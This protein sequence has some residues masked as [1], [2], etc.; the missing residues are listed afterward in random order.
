MSVYVSDLPKDGKQDG[1]P[2]FLYCPRCGARNSA[3]PSDYFM[4]DPNTKFRCGE[5]RP[6]VDMVLAR[7]DNRVIEL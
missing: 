1:R 6:L 7:A 3:N 2:V 4:A 5:H